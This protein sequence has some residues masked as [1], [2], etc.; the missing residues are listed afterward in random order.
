MRTFASLLGLIFIIWLRRHW[1]GNEL[2]DATIKTVMGLLV[3][4]LAQDICEIVRTFRDP[5]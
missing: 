4:P 2:P 3:L 5:R 1:G